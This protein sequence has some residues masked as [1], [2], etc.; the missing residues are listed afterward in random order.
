MSLTFDTVYHKSVQAIKVSHVLLNVK[1]ILLR[2]LLIKAIYNSKFYQD[3][4]FD[5]LYRTALKLATRS[6]GLDLADFDEIV[7][8]LEPGENSVVR[9]I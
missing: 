8:L 5:K 2:F 6:R 7:Q 1:L 4:P 3:L 9:A